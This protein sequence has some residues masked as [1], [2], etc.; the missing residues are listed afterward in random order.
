MKKHLFSIVTILLGL[1]LLG[2]SAYHIRLTGLASA[3][4]INIILGYMVMYMHFNSEKIFKRMRELND[5]HV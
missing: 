2:D 1:W 5:R 4:L 3:S